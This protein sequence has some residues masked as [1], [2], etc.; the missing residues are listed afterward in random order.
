MVIATLVGI[1]AAQQ[2][3]FFASQNANE[4]VI[5]RSENENNGD[6]TFRWVSETSDGSKHEQSGYLKDGPDPQAPIQ[7]IQGAY[8]YYSPEGQLIQVQYIADENGFQPVG[9][10]LPKLPPAQNV[11]QTRYVQQSQPQIQ[12][13]QQQFRPVAQQGFQRF[14]QIRRP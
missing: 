10:H 12:F 13:Q 14:Q 4:I 5:T 8:S 3:R 1:C 6:G 11:Q 7:V 2:Q 9:D